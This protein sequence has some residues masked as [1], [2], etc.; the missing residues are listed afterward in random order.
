MAIGEETDQKAGSQRSNLRR[1]GEVEM[2]LLRLRTATMDGQVVVL[3][4]GEVDLSTADPLAGY[5]IATAEQ[6]GP[7][8]I[9][10]LSAVGFLD[11]S[12]LGALVRT[13]T[14]LR[15][16]DSQL[17]LVGLQPKVAKILRLG[18]LEHVFPLYDST[19]AALADGQE[20]GQW[21]AE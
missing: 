14:H 13:R 16:R 1:P 5:L 20:H 7:R 2:D 10:D 18:R 8:L 19:A 11:C 17:V 6:H 12:G 15:A 21:D 4:C 9:L 3:A